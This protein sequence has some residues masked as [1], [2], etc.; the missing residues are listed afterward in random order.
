M[1]SCLLL[2]QGKRRMTARELATMLEVSMR[3]VY[4]DVEALGAAGVP[5]HMERGALG[6][7]VL[8][9]DY[10]RALA[11]FSTDELQAL[12]ASGPGPL[13]DLGMATPA[14]AL[15][16]LAGALPVMQRRAAE[17]SR[18]RLF[19][20][21]NRWS[22][23]EQPTGVLVTLR[24]AAEENRRVRMQYRDRTGTVTDRAIDPL[25]LVAKAGVWYV[26]SREGDKGYRTFR[27]QRIVRLD[28]LGETFVRPSDFALEAYWNESVSAIERQTQETFDVVLRVENDGLPKVSSFWE[29]AILAEDPSSTTLRVGFPSRDYAIVQILVLDAS[30]LEILSPPDM[31]A[32]IVAR[33]ADATRRYGSSANEIVIPASAK[34]K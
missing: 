25:G 12:F 7:I 3:T 2:L 11:Q 22:R 31:P 15:Q 24:K 19:V 32:A 23:G 5:I 33:A 1:I 26:I 29:H 14:A 27:A 18:E 16:K 20:D 30:V 13:A 4:R 17:A 21:H 6:G 34:P 8:A 9:D 10:R 28:V